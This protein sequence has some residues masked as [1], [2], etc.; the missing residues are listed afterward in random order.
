MAGAPRPTPPR[1]HPSVS[2]LDSCDDSVTSVPYVFL[3]PASADA[4]PPA[5]LVAEG[6]DVGMRAMS[7]EIVRLHHE[8]NNP[9]AIIS[10]NAQLLVEL[11]RA[12]DVD[13]DLL[14]PIRDIEEASRRLTDSLRGLA[15]LRDHVRPLS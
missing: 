9:L 1:L 12:M 13:E 11:A 6:Y 14:G 3:I 8:V 4:V 5:P 2:S 10:G 15:R 7:E